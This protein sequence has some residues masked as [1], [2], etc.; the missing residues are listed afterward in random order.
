MGRAKK[1]YRDVWRNR[2]TALR[3]I[4]PVLLLIWQSDRNCVTAGLIC[5]LIIGFL[6]VTALW[7]GKLIIEQ[8]ITLSC[9]SFGVL[10]YSPLIF[11]LLVSAIIPA[12]VGET[13]FAFLGYSLAYSL[14]PVKRELDYLRDLATHKESAKELKIFGLGGFLHR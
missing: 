9:L 6:P 2:V 8:V 13:H 11:V 14:T 12:F 4:P 1:I 7:V 10:L 3:N 5:R